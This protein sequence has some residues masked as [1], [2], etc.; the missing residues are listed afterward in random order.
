MSKHEAFQRAIDEAKHLHVDTVS[1][2]KS[3]LPLIA[4]ELH[5]QATRKDIKLLLKRK[6]LCKHYE[7]IPMI[8]AHVNPTNHRPLSITFDEEARIMQFYRVHSPEMSFSI[9]PTCAIIK[10]CETIGEYGL[11]DQ[12]KHGLNRSLHAKYDVL[13]NDWWARRQHELSQQVSPL[14]KL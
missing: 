14:S 2:F 4:T 10:V 3:V 11:A 13:W 6:G 12:V 8:L 9:N 5:E 7:T 1:S